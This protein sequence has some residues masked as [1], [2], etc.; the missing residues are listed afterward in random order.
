MT[1]SILKNYLKS[2][3]KDI[4]S[5]KNDLKVS[6]IIFSKQI[7]LDVTVTPIKKDKFNYVDLNN[8]IDNAFI[9]FTNNI[10][11]D[12]K[13]K[14]EIDIADNYYFLIRSLSNFVTL[15]EEN[16][17]QKGIS[18]WITIFMSHRT[19]NK[20]TSKQK[21]EDIII[22]YKDISKMRKKFDS[23][24]IKD[25]LI[26]KIDKNLIKLTLIFIDTK[27]KFEGNNNKLE[28]TIFGKTYE[29]NITNESNL[30]TIY[31]ETNEKLIK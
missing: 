17:L 31:N 25:F 6:K 13:K 8:F 12:Y 29:A 10:D 7:F 3:L 15:K 28:S 1:V 24:K 18:Q 21:E 2:N 20:D 16:I 30:L 27:L 19:N 23:D 11:D 26:D 9:N 22:D 14:K 5:Q 4:I